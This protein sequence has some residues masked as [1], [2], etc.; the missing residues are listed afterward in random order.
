MASPEL[1]FSA[2]NELLGFDL[3]EYERRQLSRS[4][5]A[6][7]ASS[8]GLAGSFSAADPYYEAESPFSLADTE[9]GSALEEYE[10]RQLS[11]SGGL[12]Y[13]DTIGH[14]SLDFYQS[15]DY[16]DWPAKFKKGDAAYDLAAVAWIRT[17]RAAVTDYPGLNKVKYHSSDYNGYNYNGHSST[18]PRPN[19]GVTDAKQVAVYEG[20]RLELFGEGGASSINT[21][22]DQILTVGWGF[23]VRNELGR[24]VLAKAMQASADFRNKMLGAGFQAE[25]GLISY[26]DT[27]A[28]TILTGDVALQKVRWDPKVL[29][30]LI[31]AAEANMADYIAAQVAIFKQYRM[32]AFPAEGFQWPVDSVRLAVHLAHWLPAGIKWGDL[33]TSGG[34]VATIVK[35]FCRNIY[36]FQESHNKTNYFL[37]I[38]KQ[39]NNALFV[40]DKDSRFHMG[41]DALVKAGTAGTIPTV[42]ATAFADT[43]K[44]DAKYAAYIFVQ[45]KEKVYLLS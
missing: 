16:Y 35:H 19:W 12:S 7:L 39:A 21:Y 34:N 45:H 32:S 18:D 2:G 44:T 33:R 28:G 36:D 15:V 23:S 22:D 8:I 17:N 3:E 40:D 5:G 27:D 38:A 37:R 20:L 14:P 24:G 41:N 42:A 13:P 25:S 6:S 9:I 26:V 31:Y 4:G 10:R 11:R 43:Y 1:S 30:Q 29:S